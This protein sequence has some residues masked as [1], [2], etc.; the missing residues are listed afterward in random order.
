M[1]KLLIVEDE[2]DLLDVAA[3]LFRA[4]GYEVLTASSSAEAI[5]LLER[6][7]DIDI[8]F[9]DVVMPNGMNGVEF[10]RLARQ[11]YPAL[12]I[13]LVSGYSLSTL[14]AEHGNLDSFSFIH[15]PYQLAELAR[16]LRQMV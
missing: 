5:D 4:I 6:I 3:E 13:I 16:K 10:A 7:G 1:E 9:S 11:R 12:K 15:K 8:L 14:Q 2:P